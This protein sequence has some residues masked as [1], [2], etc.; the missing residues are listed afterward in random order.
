MCQAA[1]GARP[2]RQHCDTRKGEND[3][4]INPADSRKNCELLFHYSSNG[5]IHSDDD[6]IEKDLNE[7]LNLNLT[8]LVKARKEAL[9]KVVEKLNE[10]FPGKTWS[11]TA[12]QK[13]LDAL[14]TPQDGMF[15]PFCQYIT[16]YLERRL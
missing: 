6:E 4:T 8:D 10:K 1:R 9:A 14:R 7:T 5:E 11:A 12:I 13:E 2:K 16:C 3:I 15:E